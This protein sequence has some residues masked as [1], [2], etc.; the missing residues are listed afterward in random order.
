MSAEMLPSHRFLAD[1]GSPNFLLQAQ[2]F[3]V[4]VMQ[5]SRLA[6]PDNLPL[7][8]EDMVANGLFGLSQTLKKYNGSGAVSTYAFPRVKGEIIDGLTRL[9]PLSSAEYHRKQ[10][11]E[12]QNTL[13]PDEE[14]ELQTLQN[15]L[16]PISW[17]TAYPDSGQMSLDDSV[18]DPLAVN[19]ETW[20]ISKENLTAVAEY[21][22]ALPEHQN[23]VIHAVLTGKTHQEIADALGIEV[24]TVRYHL[25]KIRR[26]LLH[27]FPDIFHS[28]NGPGSQPK[29]DLPHR[30]RILP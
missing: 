20:L 12:S 16:S 5:K 4:S 15:R 14:R 28:D 9:S 26:K 25:S 19:P 11:L 23:K 30:N 22:S 18:R 27:R 6:S 2:A 21:L 29:T 8:W 3:V 17:E 7:D 1:P 24:S 10:E 13:P